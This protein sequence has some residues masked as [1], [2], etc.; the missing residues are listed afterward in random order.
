[1]RKTPKLIL[2]ALALMALTLGG[3]EKDQQ[4]NGT[5]H[6]QLTD[7]PIDASDLA[8]EYLTI[9][10]IEYNLNGEWHTYQEFQGPKKLNLLDL[11]SGVVAE[12]G[13]FASKA[14]KYEQIR[15][16]LDISKEAESDPATPSCYIAFK[17][18]TI[19]PLKV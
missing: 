4:G 10:G 1:M 15:F 16:M 9:T 14:G 17:D 6:L 7:A 2:S 5:V 11:H 18:G 12:L 8:V 13:S 3:C 19:K